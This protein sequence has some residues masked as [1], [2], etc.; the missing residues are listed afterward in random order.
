M[1]EG[2]PSCTCDDHVKLGAGDNEINAEPSTVDETDVLIPSDNLNDIVLDD[3]DEEGESEENTISQQDSTSE[4]CESEEESNEEIEYDADHGDEENSILD[5]SIVLSESKNIIKLNQ[6]NQNKTNV[7]KIEDI[8]RM[9]VPE[10]PKEY[11]FLLGPD[12]FIKSAQEPWPNDVKLYQPYEVEQILLPDNANCLA[13]QAFLR[14]CQLNYTV[15]SR[16]NAE[17]MSP[18]GKVPFIKCGAFV[19]SELE[20][21]VQFV[22]NRGITLT[23]KLDNEE[24]SDMRAYM[25]LIHNVLEKAELYICWMDNETYNDVTSIRHG[26][27][28]PWPL[29]H[30]QNWTKR[31]AVIKNLKVWNWYDKK[32]EE[33]FQ[34]VENACQ[35]LSDRLDNKEYFFGNR[36]TELDALV[37]GHFFTI[38]TTPLP[39]NSFANIARK[40][41]TLIN[42]IQRIEKEYF[43]KETKH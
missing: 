31:R 38:L 34:E 37:F 39:N 20:G 40:Y 9:T 28:Y 23:E 5:E 19:V 1:E 12:S 3:I 15:D 42:L 32:L 17:A 10:R 43:K 11:I 26:S 29:N 6:S 7:A 35:A 18:T 4:E 2:N 22:N 33:V 25:C 30:I 41:P 16:A 24:K 27:V 13:V 21:I 14:M 8:N 36:P